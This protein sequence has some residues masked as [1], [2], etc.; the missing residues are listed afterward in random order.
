MLRPRPLPKV[1]VR[2]TAFVTLVAALLLAACGTIRPPA[3]DT[4]SIATLDP[5]AFEP[6]PAVVEPGRSG[7]L[8]GLRNG[9]QNGLQN[10]PRLRSGGAF[11]ALPADATPRIERIASGFPNAPYAI[12]GIEYEP[13]NEDLP[14]K[15][16]GIAS[17]YG[18][19]FHGRPASTGERFDMYGMT[20]AHPT[21]PLPSYAVVRNLDNGRQVIV[22]VNDRGPF[23]GN[24][25]IDL[26]FAAAKKLGM[27][28]LAHVEVE[29]IT[30]ADIRT[31]AWKLQSPAFDTAS[32]KAKVGPL[33]TSFESST[34]SLALESVDR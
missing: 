12:K 22:R 16:T 17:W 11:A 26:S 18:A 21:M 25:V 30:H 33:A 3:T 29:R 13:F 34:R 2:P 27:S 15:E 4:G 10:G 9:L 20:A 24:R 1:N 31:G 28:G 7:Q 6:A 19:D 14:M 5:L 32:A 23:V 8:N